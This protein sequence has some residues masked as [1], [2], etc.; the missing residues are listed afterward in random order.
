M[1]K[2]EVKA[3]LHHSEFL[4]RH[5]I[6]TSFVGTFVNSSRD[7]GSPAADHPDINLAV[8]SPA[9]VG[10]CQPGSSDGRL[11]SIGRQR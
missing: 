3:E 6:F 5:S 8:A 11:R 10:F 1:S 2:S 4:V 9:E 7:T